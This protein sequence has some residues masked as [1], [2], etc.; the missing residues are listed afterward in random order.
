MEDKYLRQLE[1]NRINYHKRKAENRN[2]QIVP[3]E[4]QKKRGRPRINIETN[5][6]KR[7]VGRPRT[8]IITEPIIK[9]PRGRPSKTQEIKPEPILTTL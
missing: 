7:H 6:E 9:R 8:R 3:I 1:I 4:M 5:Q 2:K